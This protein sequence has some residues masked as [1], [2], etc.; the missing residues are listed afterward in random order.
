MEPRV[1]NKKRELNWLSSISKLAK[2]GCFYK[3]LNGGVPVEAQW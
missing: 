2:I 3:G 1:L